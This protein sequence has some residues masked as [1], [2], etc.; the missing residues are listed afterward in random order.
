M[1]IPTPLVLLEKI[2]KWDSTC[3]VVIV[4]RRLQN[5][6]FITNLFRS[7]QMAHKVTYNTAAQI[8]WTAEGTKWRT[9]SETKS[10]QSYS[11]SEPTPQTLRAREHRNRAWLTSLGESAQRGHEREGT[12]IPLIA[13]GSRQGKRD[14]LA[15][16]RKRLIFFGSSLHYSIGMFEWRDHEVS[17][18]CASSRTWKTPD[19]DPSQVQWSSWL[20]EG[21]RFCNKSNSS[22]NS[23]ASLPLGQCHQSQT[24]KEDKLEDK[25]L[26]LIK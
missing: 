5:F 15:R 3:V 6:F 2:H 26:S 22:T 4:S 8:E 25:I 11:G 7:F 16:Q 12:D 17:K 23:E 10:S 1:P 14:L 24:K 21:D 18:A 19:E 13:N 9:S 20:E